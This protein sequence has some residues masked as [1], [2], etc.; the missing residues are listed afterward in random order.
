MTI[1]E[2][3]KKVVEL[4]AQGRKLYKLMQFGEALKYFGEALKVGTS[5]ARL[6]PVLEVVDD[7]FDMTRLPAL[8]SG[9]RTAAP[10]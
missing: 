9:P 8:T 5:R 10:S 7:S 6:A 1:T 2:E 4:F 3:K